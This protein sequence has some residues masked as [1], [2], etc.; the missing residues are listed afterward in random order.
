MPR[1]PRPRRT[2]LTPIAASLRAGSDPET[3]Q[4][5]VGQRVEG[6]EPRRDERRVPEPF[7]AVGRRPG[8]TR[9]R[10]FVLTVAAA[11][12]IGGNVAA[13]QAPATVAPPRVTSSVDRTA[14]WIADRVVFSVEI[15][16]APGVDILLDDVAKEKLRVNGLEVLSSDTSAT[17]DADGRTTHTLRYA[18]TTYRVDNASPSIESMSIR[19]YARRPGERLQDVAPAGD[20]QVPGARLAF[21]STLPENQP[22]LA[23]R[24]GRTAPPR[25]TFFSR[26]AQ[27]G[28]ALVIVALA[29]AAA[30]AVAAV[31][32][33]TAGKPARR[34]SRQ[35]KQDQ[36]AVLE[37]LRAL[38]VSS[39]DDRRRACDEIG[40][41][42]RGYVASHAHVP[43]AAL[44]ASEIDAAL[45]AR[46]G[47]IPRDTVVSLLTVV[48][49]ARYRP[50]DAPLSAEACRDA[51][52]SAEHV[53]GGR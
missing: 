10:G 33:R 45:A 1:P 41:A 12:A 15:V 18:L 47:R 19:Y 51:I 20:V 16:C 29:P 35:A 38:D 40:T 34:S 44:T 43:A 22:E 42:I 5:A 6:P 23:I 28:L 48:D 4:V 31:R 17:T 11:V 27:I 36:R 37:R 32:R 24:D 26:A 9:G 49:E 3:V 52:A 13:A 50:A 25:R 7:G 21:R 39:T 14:I 53:L 8:L 46:S 30:L 2:A